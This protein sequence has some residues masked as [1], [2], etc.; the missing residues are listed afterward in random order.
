MFPSFK[1]KTHLLNG[2]LKGARMREYQSTKKTHVHIF[3]WE[4]SILIDHSYMNAKK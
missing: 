4:L 2:V 1:M 3:F